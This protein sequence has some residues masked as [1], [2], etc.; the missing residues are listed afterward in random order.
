MTPKPGDRFSG[1]TLG[2]TIP[3]SDALVPVVWVIAGPP[4]A[5]ILIQAILVDFGESSQRL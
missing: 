1:S 4:G 2:P 5:L 3:A